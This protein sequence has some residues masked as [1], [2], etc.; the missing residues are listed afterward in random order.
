MF[1]TVSVPALHNLCCQP[2]SLIT[3]HQPWRVKSLG[4]LAVTLS[5]RLTGFDQV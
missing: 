4:S 2:I 5:V 3:G 1:Q